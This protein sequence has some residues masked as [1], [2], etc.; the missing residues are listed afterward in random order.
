MREREV[1]VQLGMSADEVAEGMR[2][3]R[4]IKGE[5]AKLEYIH[6]QEE[7]ATEEGEQ[8]LS[9]TF[10]VTRWGWDSDGVIYMA[11]A[12]GHPENDDRAYY[13]SNN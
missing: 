2:F 8:V 9:L 10:Y 3:F 11:Y 7:A 5:I 1:H 13:W 12:E 4:E 6:A